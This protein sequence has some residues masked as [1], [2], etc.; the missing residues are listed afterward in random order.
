MVEQGGIARWLLR[1]GGHCAKQ[2]YLRAL[3]HSLSQ[4]GTECGVKWA[5]YVRPARRTWPE[6]HIQRSHSAAVN[7][8]SGARQ[9]Q[10]ARNERICP[11][12]YNSRQ[13]HPSLRL[14]RPD[15]KATLPRVRPRIQIQGLIVFLQTRLPT[16]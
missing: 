15:V 6:P 5:R 13:V 9:I 14:A 8:L 12:P 16:L 2:N 10:V 1:P 4:T 7:I 3:H 11:P